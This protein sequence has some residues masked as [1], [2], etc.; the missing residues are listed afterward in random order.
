MLSPL[1]LWSTRIVPFIKLGRF[2]FLAGGFALYGLGVAIALYSGAAINWRV[3]IWGQ[4]IVTATQL[5]VHYSNDYY[6]F[7]ADRVNPTPTAWSGGSG[8]LQSGI[9][10]RRTAFVAAIILMGIAVVGVFLLALIEHP[11]PLT[12]PIVL[13]AVGLSWAYSSP[14]I[15]LHSRGIGEICG[16]FIVSGLTPLFGYYLR[17]GQI[18][19]LPLLA[20]APLCCLQLNMLLSVD[21]PDAE[22]D[23]T[24]HKRT[25]VVRLGRPAI[26]RIYLVSLACAYLILPTVVLLGL[27]PLVALC[28]TLSFP[29]ALWL[30]WRILEGDWARPDRQGRLPFF[31]IAL[32]MGATL[33]ELAAFVG[34]AMRR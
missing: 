30:A 1:R 19:S 32:L 18:T 4:I 31:S 11:G 16:V 21:L 17:A 5:M 15:K 24:A 20:I 25:L 2:L 9:L 28:F 7:E 6:D 29:L 14:P 26:A 10:P 34:L 3:A 23:A 27:P 22:G 33:L 8:V 12:V 13:L